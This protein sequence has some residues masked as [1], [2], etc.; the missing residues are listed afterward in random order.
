MKQLFT[1][2]V[3]VLCIN[4]NAQNN[5]T[6][7]F[8]V[9]YPYSNNGVMSIDSMGGNW[10]VGAPG[11]SIFNSAISGENVLITDTL[12]PYTINQDSYVYFSLNID[13]SWSLGTGTGYAKMIFSFKTDLDSLND[14]A[15]LEIFENGVWINLTDSWVFTSFH[16]EFDQNYYLPVEYNNHYLF[17][18][19]N[20]SWQTTVINVSCWGIFQPE[21]LE[22]GGIWPW[23]NFRFHF[24]SDSIFD[25]REGFILDDLI[26][27]NF[28]GPCFGQVK[29]E[30]NSFQISVYPTLT[31]GQINFESENSIFQKIIIYDHIGKQVENFNFTP[32]NTLTLQLDK[33]KVGMYFYSVDEGKSVGKFI[34][35]DK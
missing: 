7:N 15:E 25:N 23:F 1:I 2:L 17:T 26:W 30:V 33:L 34:V 29:E 11:K 5:D 9:L 31:D 10:Q 35:Q 27:E 14:Y 22:R 19:L 18:G 8:D 13:D 12:D 4:T 24:H 21:N 16:F 6:I 28:F 32:T 20:T 3:S